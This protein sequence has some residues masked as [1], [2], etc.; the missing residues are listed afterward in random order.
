MKRAYPERD[1]CNKQPQQPRAA[2]KKRAPKWD[3]E[4]DEALES[5]T[6]D[7]KSFTWD[8]KAKKADVHRTYKQC[9]DRF[10][11][12][13]SPEI[14]KG[15][16]TVKE[17]LKFMELH[18]L[19]G[20]NWSAIREKMPGKAYSAP[21]NHFNSKVGKLI[22]S[23]KNKC[24]EIPRSQIVEES[25][26]FFWCIW[27]CY[28]QVRNTSD[29][30]GC[31]ILKRKISSIPLSELKY[32]LEML[33]ALP[34]VPDLGKLREKLLLIRKD[35]GLTYSYCPPL[36]SE[37]SRNVYLPFRVISDYR[38][39]LKAAPAIADSSS[40]RPTKRNPRPIIRLEEVKEVE[41]KDKRVEEKK[42]N[43]N[44]RKFRTSGRGTSLS[45]SKACSGLKEQ[46]STR[47]ERIVGWK[48][49]AMLGKNKRVG[50]N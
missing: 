32:Y 25:T 14:S 45:H 23:I 19:Y 29:Q 39:G 16:W 30:N 21:K 35:L 38:P 36:A 48:K 15:P 10:H 44:P 46:L 20:N 17:R 7:F 13:V 2:R 26:Y 24:T 4:D 43:G 12:V 9:W 11:E 42:T 31:T 50:N 22:T 37:I 41:K 18:E 28:N 3:S 33:W 8:Y 5:A 47:R 49:I 40:P 27:Q 34:Q 1:Y 6:Q